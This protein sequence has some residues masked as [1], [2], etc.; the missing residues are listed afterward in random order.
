MNLVKNAIILE[1]KKRLFSN[2]AGAHSSLF[3]GSGVEFRDLQEYNTSDSARHINWK[4]SSKSKVYVNSFQADRELNI[5][6]LYLNSGSLDFAGKKQKA[7][8]ALTAISFASIESKE[9]LSTIF[10]NQKEQ[11]F[12]APSKKR[13]IIDLNF[14]IANSVKYQSEI[15]YKMLENYIL[16]SIKKRSIIF[17][18]G[19]F[20]DEVNLQTISLIHEV[21][22]VIIRAKEEENLEL[23]GELNIVDKNSQSQALLNINKSSQKIYNKL[24]KEQENRLF[25]HFNDCQINYTKVYNNSNTISKLKELING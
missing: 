15:D 11:K 17:I 20:L 5:V 25:K 21:Y 8:E 24:F 19:D 4:K 6:L 14:D 18:I 3:R 12:F 22:A 13:A 7:I 16:H 23:L 1:T 10:F 2:L 9:S